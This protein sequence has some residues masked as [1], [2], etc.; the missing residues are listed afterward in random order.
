MRRSS[1]SIRVYHAGN[2]GC[3]NQSIRCDQS[4]FMCASFLGSSKWIMEN[5][6]FSSVMWVTGNCRKQN[7]R[8]FSRSLSLGRKSQAKLAR[9][10]P[11]FQ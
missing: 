5:K 10:A 9:R 4:R 11:S 1:A 2:G 3:A 8:V 7:P 6:Y